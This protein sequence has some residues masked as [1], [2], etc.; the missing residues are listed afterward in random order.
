MLLTALS[1]YNQSFNIRAGYPVPFVHR[2]ILCVPESHSLATCMFY[3]YKFIIIISSCVYRGQVPSP[4]F[5]TTE[6]HFTAQEVP[7]SNQKS[8]F[9]HRYLSCSAESARFQPSLF[10]PYKFS[11]PETFTSEIFDR[12]FFRLAYK[13]PGKLQFYIHHIASRLRKTKNMF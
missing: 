9:L 8:F 1:P 4:L 12:D 2:N 13:N 5:Y 10:A 7:F 11:S 3:A 6:N